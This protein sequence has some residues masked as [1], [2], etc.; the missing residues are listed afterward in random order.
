MPLHI[1]LGFTEIIRDNH[2]DS[3]MLQRYL[4]G[5]KV[6]GEYM[7]TLLN[8]IINEDECCSSQD[9]CC[10]EAPVLPLNSESYLQEKISSVQERTQSYDF[11]GKR[12]L[13]VDD[14]AINREIVIQLLKKTGAVTEFAEN[15]QVCLEMIKAAPPGFYD[16]VLMDI[17]MPKMDGLNATREIRRLPGKAKSENSDY[18]PYIKCLRKGPECRVKCRDGCFCRKA[19]LCRKTV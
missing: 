7:I 9:T 5:I 4:D 1:I 8:R 16:M 14:M 3:E 6:S 19:N 11:T 15:G 17:M 10:E 13:V 2:C 18:R 12:I